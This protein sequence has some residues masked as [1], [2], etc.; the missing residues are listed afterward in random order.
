MITP[1]INPERPWPYTPE[2]REA[3]RARPPTGVAR[4]PPQLSRWYRTRRD[5]RQ[6]MAF[7]DRMLQ[8]IGLSR[9]EIEARCEPD[10]RSSESAAAAGRH[11]PVGTGE[12]GR[13]KQATRVAPHLRLSRHGALA[14]PGNARD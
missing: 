2:Q 1:T 3:A 12:L 6:L 14:P 11:C 8:D 4:L 7:D 10:A 9:G 5:A 13:P